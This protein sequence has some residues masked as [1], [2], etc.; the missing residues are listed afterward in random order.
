VLEYDFVLSIRRARDSWLMLAST[1]ERCIQFSL[2]V[3]YRSGSMRMFSVSKGAVGTWLVVCVVATPLALA[4]P[5]ISGVA[6]GPL[7]AGQTVTIAGSGFGNKAKA[8]PVLWDN[9]EGGTIGKQIQAVPAA[10]G[11]WDT[12]NGS[13]NVTYTKEKTHAGTMA[14][15]NDF[16]HAYNASL[17][18]NMTFTRLYMDYW[19]VVDYV[20]VKSRN[21]KPWRF[22]GDADN[23][24]LNYV[25]MCNDANGLGR[26]QLNANLALAA[27]GG[28]QFSNR[29]W[30]HI[31]LVYNE[32]SPGQPNGT[33]RHFIN[34][35]VA[36]LD[37]G[38]VVTEN[39]PAHFDQI[40]IGHYWDQPS[41]DNCPAN[42]GA[43][44][45]VDDVYIDTS[46][47]RVELGDA[48]TYAASMHREIQ[49]ATNWADGSVSVTFNPGSFASGATAYLFVTDANNVTSRGSPVKIGNTSVGTPGSPTNV[50]VQ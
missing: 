6:G 37:S 26:T 18:K 40:R 45:Y 48:S 2:G 5:T 13:D 4:A 1:V 29:T 32:S 22:Y 12:G 24:Q 21:F 27:W 47:A 31:Q 42:G 50:A 11:Q 19:M 8:L 33:I 49:V 39:L 20:D 14:A 7:S 15:R 9:F 16:M 35:H 10:V 17:A 46:W 36:G 44:V 34:S 43:V 41:D 25:W 3:W 30:M 28:P 38:A 23:Y